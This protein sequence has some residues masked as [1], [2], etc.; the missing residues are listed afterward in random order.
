[1]SGWAGGVGLSGSVNDGWLF[2]WLILSCSASIPLTVRGSGTFAGGALMEELA[3]L[4]MN[5]DITD[6]NVLVLT[7]NMLTP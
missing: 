6:L 5:T 1:M 4:V 7:Q 2:E 3:G